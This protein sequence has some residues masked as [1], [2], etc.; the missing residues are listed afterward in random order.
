MVLSLAPLGDG[1]AKSRTNDATRRG[2]TRRRHATTV[3]SLSLAALAHLLRLGNVHHFDRLHWLR[4]VHT[5]RGMREAH[6]VGFHIIQRLEPSP[7]LSH[8]LTFFFLAI[9]FLTK[10]TSMQ[11]E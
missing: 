3:A 6:D 9:F 11:Y 10:S 4:L 8:F 2:S 7:G 1:Y 5:K